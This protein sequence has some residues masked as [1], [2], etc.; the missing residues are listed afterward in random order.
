GPVSYSSAAP[1]LVDVQQDAR[2]A[3]AHRGEERQPDR[4]HDA[5]RRETD[6]AT[7][8]PPIGGNAVIRPL[9]LPGPQ[10]SVSLRMCA[11]S[12]AS[13]AATPTSGAVLS[14]QHLDGGCDSRDPRVDGL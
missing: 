6:R 8:R 2:I 11:S 5:V 12:A 9:V 1:C 3:R 4:V 7:P 10:G 13:G 14:S